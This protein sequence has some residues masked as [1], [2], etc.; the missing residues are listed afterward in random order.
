[1]LAGSARSGA[2]RAWQRDRRAE[3]GDRPDDQ[4]VAPS[5]MEIELAMDS[6]VTDQFEAGLRWVGFLDGDGAV[7][8]GGG[9]AL[10]APFTVPSTRDSPVLVHED[11]R[12]RAYFR[13]PGDGPTL[14]LEFEPVIARE[15]VAS[16]RRSLVLAA[17]VAALLALAGVM[18]WR[19]SLRFEAAELQM[20]EQ[21]RLSA[22]GEMSAVLAHE[23]RNPLASLKGN[24]QLLVERMT[25]DSNERRKVERIVD[26]ATRLE[27]LT[28]D[29]LDFA[30]AGPLHL[31]EVDPLELVESS[32]H[33]AAPEMAVAVN[34]TE[35]LSLW[36]LEARRFRQALVNLIRNAAQASSDAEPAEVDV[37]TDAHR[38]VITV[39]DHG[40]GLPVGQEDRI[41]DPF[42]TTR[43]TG[44]G[45]GLPVSK[46]IVELHGGALTAE[47]AADGGAVFRIE[48]PRAG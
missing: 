40:S 35:P 39:R 26:E 34:A 18:L 32:A 24:A 27:A 15:M 28:S 25:A 4:R 16:A 23:I 14:A 33:E 45:L 9:A 36:P 30:G 2:F 42:F 11:G 22:L 12:V 43:T 20:Q 41:F 7:L 47:N 29:L 44:T 3:S 17:I 13:P 31:Q 5:D 38:L 6:V 37:A 8:A 1:M 21:R 10:D 46:R 48:I 19:L